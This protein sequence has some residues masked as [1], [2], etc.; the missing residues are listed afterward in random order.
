[1]KI[2]LECNV[3]Y[4]SDKYL[5]DKKQFCPEHGNVLEPV[6][7]LNDRYHLLTLIGK[8]AMG[9]VY[10]VQDKQL[11]RLC[12]IKVIRQVEA[13]DLT[14][15]KKQS[16]GE[17]RFKREATISAQL[18]HP[19][20]VTV[21]DFGVT[22]NKICFIAMEYLQGETLEAILEREKVLSIERITSILTQCVDALSEAHEKAIVHRDLKPANIMIIR[23]RNQEQ[24]KIMDF[25]LAK[26][27]TNNQ[28]LTA[29]SKILGTPLYVS[30]EQVKQSKDIDGRSD[31]YTLALLVYQMLTGRLPFYGEDAQEVIYKR[32][33]EDPLPPSKLNPNV[34]ISTL[35]DEAI[36]KALA[37]NRDKRTST[38]DKFLDDF[39]KATKPANQTAQQPIQQPVSQNSPSVIIQPSPIIEVIS[40]VPQQKKQIQS[41]EGILKMEFVKIPLGEFMM[42]S[43]GGWLG[44]FTDFTEQPQHLVE[45]NYGFEMG[46]AQVT[47]AQWETIMG[48]NP[49]YFKGDGQLPVEAVSW[50]DVQEFIKKLN[51]KS[52]GYTYR[53]PSEAE[54]EYA[55][56]A[57]TIGDYA[58]DLYKMAWYS[59]NSGGKTHRVG[60]KRPNAWGL[61]DMHGN[62]W[63]WCQDSWHSNYNGA[64]TDGSVWNIETDNSRRVLRGGSWDYNASFCRSAVRSRLR[65]GYHGDLYGFRVVRVVRVIS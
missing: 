19:N 18:S 65:P 12:A 26:V 61:Y 21:Y 42:G 43:K 29:A 17:E 20:I 62:V 54:W 25:G 5:T 63:E 7:D 2:C 40:P 51:E 31:I 64:P 49:S 16:E 34:F 23:K 9:L 46:A 8:G 41:I 39:I 53:L 35:L 58:G 57:G 14:D 4:T 13:E 27:I 37:K 10:Q 59:Q 60:Q 44:W 15:P 38:M 36:L 22:S 32:L 24:V 28:K 47:Q 33:L 52:S 11:D 50:I 45:I 3:A 55:C 48:S 30:P 56:R 1:M 6:T